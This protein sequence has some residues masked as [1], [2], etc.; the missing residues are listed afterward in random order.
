MAHNLDPF[1]P[2]PHFY[3]TFPQQSIKLWL[4]F[5]YGKYHLPDLFFLVFRFGETNH[6]F[7][8][9]PQKLFSLIAHVPQGSG[10]V[11]QCQVHQFIYDNA[12]P[13]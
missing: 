9:Q 10:A 7:Q 5:F 12:V 13:F 4:H 6:L 3:R 2:Y 1:F 11:P 8:K